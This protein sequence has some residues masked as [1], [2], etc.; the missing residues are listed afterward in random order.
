LNKHH[1]VLISILVL[2]AV[3]RF[4]N[5]DATEFKYDEARVSNLAAHFCDTGIPPVRGMGSSVGID[6]PP[7]TIYLLSLPILFSRDPLIVTA[8]VVLLN[9]AA[10]WGCYWIGRR[11][12]GL[13][14]GLVAAALLAISPWAVFYSRKVWAQD[15]ILPFVIAFFA[16]H[17]EWLVE[18]KRWALTGTIVTLAALTQ[19][20]MATVAF[21]PILGLSLILTWVDPSRRSRYPTLWRP[22]LVGIGVS[23]LLYLPYLAFDALTGWG[24]ARA[25]IE[26]A[27]A[28]AQTHWEAVRFALLNIGGREIHALSGPERFGEFLNGILDLD[29][30]PDRIEESLA[31]LGTA[32]LMIRLWYKRHDRR[33]RLRDGLLLLW[34]IMPVLF[35]VRSKSP[36]FP[37]YLIPLYPAPYLA[38]AIGASDLLSAAG[39]YDAVKK[40]L[41]ALASVSMLALVLWQSYLSLS[42]HAFVET[43]HTPNGMGTPVGILRDVARTV[44]RYV[45]TWHSEQVVILC[46][47]D[48]PGMDECPAVFQF[49]IGRSMKARFADYDESLLFPWQD[50]P[51]LVVLAPGNSVAEQE[52]LRHASSLSDKEIW[53]RERRGAYRFYQLP[54]RYIPEPDMQP[55]NTPVH[56]ENG[57][58]LLGYDLSARP[59]PGQ[60]TRLTL[61]WSVDAVPDEPPAQGY[62]F[63]NHL[64]AADGQRYGQR[65]GPGYHVRW[66][67]PRDTLASWFE[68]PLSADAPDSAY[69]LRIGVYV[70]TPPGQF[71]AVR[72]TDD[73]GQP[74]TDAIE[75]PIE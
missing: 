2:A 24:N 44:E 47:G 69:R 51:T 55:D 53:L 8:F 48:D 54:A 64:L 10:V 15:L 11:Y 27:Q 74:I 1:W 58:S 50:T 22:L 23:A 42:I 32:Y 5:L 39:A 68:I 25:L 9:I 19:I 7:L 36:V 34:L 57:I 14:A 16:F 67:Q 20:H 18:H 41:Y 3:L 71:D 13:N 26:I 21:V 6:N 12:W 28:P 17:L 72:V 31:L 37:H 63:A 59:T 65:D 40:P 38:L 35:Y 46:P 29:Y 66:W 75:W 49:M 43:H 33:L 73:T 56:V 60:T 52:L 62:S 30:W 61:Y 4:W 70:F 45:D